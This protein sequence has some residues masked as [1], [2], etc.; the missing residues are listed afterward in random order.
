MLRAK[1]VALTTL[2]FSSYLL[3][4]HR[5]PPIAVLLLSGIAVW[6]FACAQALPWVEPGNER[7]KH[8][9]LVLADAT[10]H[11]TLT[12]TWPMPWADIKSV[13]DSVE[14]RTLSAEALWSFRFLKHELRNANRTS[15]I[16]QHSYLASS[17]TAIGYF[18]TDFREDSQ[19]GV[20]LDVVGEKFAFNLAGQYAHNPTDDRD[21][22]M[23]GAFASVL[24][25]NWAAGVGTIDRWWGPGWESSLILSHSARPVPGLFLQRHHA[26][27]FSTPWLSWLGP[28]QLITFMG[29]LEHD[30][31][32]PDARLW[33]MRLTL[34][35]LSFME[36]GLSRT[37]QWGG[38]GRPG[39][40][41]TFFN[42]LVG[43]D[44]RGD[45]D[46]DESNEP[47]NQLA[48]FDIRL[49]YTLAGIQG[50]LYAQLIG[51]DEA[52]GLPSRHIGMGGV[53]FSGLFGN[54]QWRTSLEAHNTTVYFYDDKQPKVISVTDIN[55][56]AY[57]LAYEHG[58]YKSGYRYLGRP[59]GASTDNDSE[60]ITA[61]L[62][63][64]RA[65]GHQVSLSLAKLRI[66][67]D[68][69]NR[70][71]GG[72]VFGANEITDTHLTIEYNMP[73]SGAWAIGVGLFHHSEPL[74][75][76]DNAIENGGYLRL[77]SQW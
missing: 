11:K 14:P 55:R 18:G 52:G 40:I 69:S 25:G 3:R 7:I 56:P 49:N 8:H 17:P 13:L 74:K 64:Y 35:P 29:E 43:N 19:A 12:S 58:I 65:N 51:E 21:F 77:E 26:V 9:L 36:L 47:G 53:E 33:G 60:S 61:R 38:E 50:G 48:G 34:K 30:R 24:L 10:S 23:D 57:N 76:Q 4:R 37:A 41:K 46:I 63:L 59:I 67:M 68:G 31:H 39:D 16:R 62:Q 20:A 66:N 22:R 1:I 72:N 5:V 45:G 75:L 54:T 27:P 70:T 32:I 28:W 44:N 71:I 73:L 2:S 15:T 6:P 42:L